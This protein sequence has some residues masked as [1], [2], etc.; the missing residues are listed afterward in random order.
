[1]HCFFQVMHCCF[2]FT[3]FGNLFF[4]DWRSLF[5][6]CCLWKQK[7]FS[8]YPYRTTVSF[9]GTYC[10][11]AGFLLYTIFYII[12]FLC[13]A[14]S[15]NWWYYGLAFSDCNIPFHWITN[16][17]ILSDA[18]IKYHMNFSVQW[19][20]LWYRTS[21]AVPSTVR[22]PFSISNESNHNHNIWKRLKASYW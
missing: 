4:L 7:W 19:P 10:S 11:P 3:Y 18:C 21:L 13:L 9:K 12:S 17:I 2:Y 6:W 1:M 8:H 15:L 5:Y 16:H 20:I 22:I 14:R